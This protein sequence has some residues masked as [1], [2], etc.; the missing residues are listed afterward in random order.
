MTRPILK[1]VMTTAIA[2]AMFSNPSRPGT[3][4]CRKSQARPDRQG[5]RVEMPRAN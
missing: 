1:L 5:A 4:T 2:A 3:S